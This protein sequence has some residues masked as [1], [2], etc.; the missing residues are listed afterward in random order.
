MASLN[1]WITRT[2]N[3]DRK[4]YNLS[5]SLSK[6]PTGKTPKYYLQKSQTLH[7]Q[8]FEDAN[9]MPPMYDPFVFNN[10]S[11][12]MVKHPVVLQ[13]PLLTSYYN[14]LLYYIQ[15]INLCIF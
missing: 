8:V 9:K 5:Q 14:V 1:L 12:S 13:K 7:D 2:T 15:L 10:Y 11:K 6:R 4:R 3:S